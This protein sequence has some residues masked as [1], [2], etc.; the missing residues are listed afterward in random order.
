MSKPVDLSQSSVESENNSNNIP[1]KDAGAFIHF[2]I[3][4]E[5]IGATT[6]RLEKAALVGSYFTSLSDNNLVLA[7]LYFAGYIFP[8]RDRRR[9]NI[10]GAALLS[11][12]SAVTG[13]E[14]T[15]LQEKLVKLG[16]PGDV[17]ARS[18]SH[19]PR[20]EGLQPILTLAELSHRLEQL[21][22]T[23][24]TKRKVELVT[25]LLKIATPLEAKYIVK[26]LAGDLRIGLKEGAVED[27]IARLYKTDISRVQWV[28]M[29]TGDIG[30]TAILA[31]RK[32]LDL[33]RM[34]LFH[35]IKFMLASPAA[36]LSE[37]A[38]QFPSGFAVEDKYDGIRAQV[39]IAP[40]AESSESIL[41]GTVCNGRRVAIFSRTL[42]E[43]T[44]SFPDLVEPLAD[45][46]PNCN[47]SEENGLILDGEIVPVMGEQI[48]PFQ[49]LQKRLGRKKVSEELQAAVSVAFIAYDVLYAQ[50]RVTIDEP[51]FERRKVLESL[52]LDYAKVRT[53]TSQRF[54]DISDLDAE[55]MAAR[56]RGNE[57]LMVKDFNFSPTIPLQ[58]ALAKLIQRY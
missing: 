33:A 2:A 57:G 11:A 27:A 34:Q 43:I 16:D 10:G 19:N 21:A 56:S 49:E 46:F 51:F 25:Q 29:I 31:R 7:A 52:H 39:H 13:E 37:V 8:L 36:D 40:E 5:Q 22:V 53:C 30:Q 45:I 3:V 12:I 42:D 28:N 32:Q 41:H 4:A 24:G 15:S 35:P 14:K 44:P 58:Y 48:L 54:A 9:I 26:L 47:S 1:E 38:E 20:F 18:F 50:N 6:K 55:F 23:T 17:T